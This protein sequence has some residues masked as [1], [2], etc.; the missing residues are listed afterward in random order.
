[1]GGTSSIEGRK[2]RRQLR[3][4]YLFVGIAWNRAS[5]LRSMPGR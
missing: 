2:P 4:G 5:E 3:F 1:M